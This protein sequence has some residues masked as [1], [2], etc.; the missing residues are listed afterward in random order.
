MSVLKSDKPCE[1][2]GKKEEYE[3][4]GKLWKYNPA[5][6]MY[7]GGIKDKTL[8]SRNNITNDRLRPFYAVKG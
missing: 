2:C 1:K 5:Y 7:T 6:Y 4:D 8:S 3:K